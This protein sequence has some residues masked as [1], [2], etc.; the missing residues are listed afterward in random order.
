[1]SEQE[2]ITFR[3]SKEDYPELHEWLGNQ[4]NKTRSIV[5]AIDQL[6]KVKGSEQDIIEQTLNEIDI[7]E[8]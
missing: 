3:Y 4:K 2:R 8:E 5:Y 1:M 6:I 7:Y